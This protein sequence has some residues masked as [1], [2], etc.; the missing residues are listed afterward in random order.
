MRLEI[1]Q[2]TMENKLQ[3]N[4][5]NDTDFDVLNELRTFQENETEA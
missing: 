2:A 4:D 5:T 1:Q 3:K